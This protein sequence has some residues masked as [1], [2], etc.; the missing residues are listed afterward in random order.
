M[1]I[2]QPWIQQRRLEYVKHDHLVIR[3]LRYFQEH[4]VGK[5]LTDEGAPN[6]SVIRGCDHLSLSIPYCFDLDF[7]VF[8]CT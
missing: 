6:I 7:S 5:L 1:Q 2:F 3:I 4:A 8:L